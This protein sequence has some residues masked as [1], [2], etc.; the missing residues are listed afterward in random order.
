MKID[1]KI[2]VIIVFFLLIGLNIFLF[3]K[4]LILTEAVNHL[5]KETKRLKLENNQLER[6]LYFESSLSQLKKKAKA[7]GFTKKAEP[8]FLENLKYAFNQ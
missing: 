4:G 2:V 7:M 8:F 3:T 6:E 5:E 1:L